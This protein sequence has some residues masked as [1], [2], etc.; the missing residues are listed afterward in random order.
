MQPRGRRPSFDRE[1]ALGTA[2][3]LFWRHGYEGVGIIDLTRAI[4]IAAPSLY[5]A[6]GSKADLYREALRRYASGGVSSDDI[7]RAASSKD[8]AR[9]MLE[10]GIAAVTASGKPPGCMV[11]SGMLMTSV[12][13]AELA[14]ELEG[15][16]TSLR[17]ALERRI[18]RDIEEKLL[19]SDTDAAALARFLA[20]VLQGISVQALDG[21]GAAELAPLAARALEAWPSHPPQIGVSERPE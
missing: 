2:L 11:S 8:A 5:Y 6:F 18:G 20:A 4:G 17:K 15:M 10:R 16:R 19:P 1:E 12:D 7:A 14:A 13:N 21:A 3:D 9:Q